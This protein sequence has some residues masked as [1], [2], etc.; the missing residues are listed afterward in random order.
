MQQ[1]K[2]NKLRLKTPFVLIGVY[3]LWRENPVTR[4]CEVV[5]EILGTLFA[6]IRHAIYATVRQMIMIMTITMTMTMMMMMMIIVSITK[7]SIMIGSPRSYL[8]CN[9]RSMTWVSNYRYP[10]STFSDWIPVIWYPRD[11]HVNY[12]RFNSF[13]RTISYSFQ[14]FWKALPTFSFKRHF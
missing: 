13:I 14:N 4:Y 10:I 1:W 8:S 6:T 3:G 12:A 7:F 2:Q 11:F 5:C 9:R